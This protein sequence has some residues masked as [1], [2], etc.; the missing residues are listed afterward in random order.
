MIK[1]VIIHYGQQGIEIGK[2]VVEVSFRRAGAVE[3]VRT[4]PDAGAP[5]PR[6]FHG[7]YKESEHAPGLRARRRGICSL[8]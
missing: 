6:V 2:S 7:Q 3:V 8:L 1:D 5:L 4:S